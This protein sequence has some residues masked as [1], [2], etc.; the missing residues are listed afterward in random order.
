MNSPTDPVLRK[1]LRRQLDFLDASSRAYDGGFHDEGLRLAVAI[2]VILHQ[3]NHSHSLL[4]QMGERDNIRL[5]SSVR[6][7]TT[8]AAERMTF[9]DGLTAVAIPGGPFPKLAIGSETTWKKV[10]AW[11]KQPVIVVSQSTWVTRKDII[12]GAANKDGGAHFDPK[13]SA[14]FAQLQAGIWAQADPATG[15]AIGVFGDHHLAAVRQLA[16]ELLNSP[17]LVRLSQ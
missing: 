14:E 2:R 16:W 3:T 9:Y 5:L 6:H 11:Y 17:E 7:F 4:N 12:L 1:Q 10:D 13:V 15:H 8:D